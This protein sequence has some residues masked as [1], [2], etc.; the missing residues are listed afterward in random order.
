MKMHS[1]ITLSKT[2]KGDT[3]L[4]NV[5]TPIKYRYVLSPGFR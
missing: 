5:L 3:S 2:V 1:E 4:T